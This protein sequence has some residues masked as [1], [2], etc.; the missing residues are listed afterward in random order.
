MGLQSHFARRSWDL[1]LHTTK[2]DELDPKGWKRIFAQASI[3]PLGIQ[4]VQNL[5][6]LVLICLWC[7]PLKDFQLRSTR[8]TWARE[9]LPVMSWKKL[10]IEH[11][12][13]VESIYAEERPLHHGNGQMHPWRRASFDEKACSPSLKCDEH[14]G[15][16]WT[17]PT[18]SAAQT[19]ADSQ[20][21][22]PT[23]TA[24]ATQS[25]WRSRSRN[26]VASFTKLPGKDKSCQG[27]SQIK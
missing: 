19:P 3:Q 14:F 12:E 10:I 20:H 5:P 22:L 11:A 26:G 9:G 18:Q 17:T 25:R 21:L 2:E 13:A 23:E 24:S 27:I 16:R 8:S 4:K 15:I 6:K 7:S 1:R